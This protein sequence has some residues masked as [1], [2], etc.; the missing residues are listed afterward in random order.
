MMMERLV[1]TLHDLYY[2]LYDK[3]YMH[4]RYRFGYENCSAKHFIQIIRSTTA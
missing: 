3:Y 1:Q 2:L 4:A